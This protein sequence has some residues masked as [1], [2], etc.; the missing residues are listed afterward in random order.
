MFDHF[1]VL[2]IKELRGLKSSFRENLYFVRLALKGLKSLV[3]KLSYGKRTTRKYGL[4]VFNLDDV[5]FRLPTS[6]SALVLL[7]KALHPSFTEMLPG[8]RDNDGN[9]SNAPLKMKQ[10]NHVL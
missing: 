7:R 4:V 5:I 6:S 1:V 9:K 2:A 10:G 3:T 8:M